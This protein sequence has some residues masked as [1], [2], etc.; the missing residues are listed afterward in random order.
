MLNSFPLFTS[1][2]AMYYILSLQ[3]FYKDGFGIK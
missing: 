2:Q 3:F 1:I